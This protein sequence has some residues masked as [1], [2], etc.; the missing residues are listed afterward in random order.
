MFNKLLMLSDAQ[1]KDL[2]EHFRNLGIC[3]AIFAASDWQ[4]AQ[5]APLNLGLS[6]FNTFIFCLLVAT[7]AWLLLVAQVQAFRKF[8]NYGLH[9]AKL[10]LFFA[11]YGLAVCILMISIFIH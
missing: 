2:F 5:I 6:L 11:I 8:K 1:I 10:K 7:G 9:G 4:Y 3:S